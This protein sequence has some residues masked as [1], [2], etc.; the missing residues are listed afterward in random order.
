MNDPTTPRQETPM[1]KR[2]LVMP[3]GVRRMILYT[4]GDDVP[5]AVD[6]A[7]EPHEREVRRPN[8]V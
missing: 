1:H 6:E 5:A 7:P 3:D 2:S 4:F 8:G